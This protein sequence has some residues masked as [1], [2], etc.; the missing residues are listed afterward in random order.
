MKQEIVDYGK[1]RF[2]EIETQDNPAFLN[3]T[4]VMVGADGEVAEA[5]NLGIDV[6][7]DI[8]ELFFCVACS[9]NSLDEKKHVA[10][11]QKKSKYIFGVLVDSKN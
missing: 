8:E 4:C 7:Y 2:H 1:F 9:R 10:L 6:F 11:R 5:K 3:Q